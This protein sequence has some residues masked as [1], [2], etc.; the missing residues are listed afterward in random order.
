MLIPTFNLRS[1]EVMSST[2]WR[3]AA[4]VCLGVLLVVAAPAPASTT[5]TTTFQVSLVISNDCAISA[6]ALSFGTSGVLSASINQSTT[7]SVTCSNTTPYSVGLDAGSV[8]GSTVTT[9]LLGNGSATVQ[10]QL[11]SDS[12]RTTVWGNTT[13]TNTVSGTG[14]GSAQSLTV[15]GEVPAQST[16]AAN[17]YT[18]TVTASVTF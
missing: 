12:A 1:F 11:Y 15:Y 7:L 16:P 17:T 4:L 8:S 18:S 5:K 6:N 3:C 13:G 14:T 10:F 9:R 2:I